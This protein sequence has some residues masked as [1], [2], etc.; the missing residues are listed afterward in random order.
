M[1]R[2]RH[3]ALPERFT[4]L[5]NPDRARAPGPAEEANNGKVLPAST[6]PPPRA[7]RTRLPGPS[8]Q[9]AWPAPAQR[10]GSPPD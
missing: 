3:A 8:G 2:P 1:R 9:N 5:R 4:R 6:A 7:G 10:T